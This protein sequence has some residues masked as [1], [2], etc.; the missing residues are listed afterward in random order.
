MTSNYGNIL[1]ISP[2]IPAQAHKC[3]ILAELKLLVKSSPAAFHFTPL[4]LKPT[5]VYKLKMRPQVLFL[6]LV[7]FCPFLH[8]IDTYF[9]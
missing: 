7:R 6:R 2:V 3:N 9:L 5:A 4:K 8:F 1:Y